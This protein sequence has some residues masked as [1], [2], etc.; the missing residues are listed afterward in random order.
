MDNIFLYMYMFL[1]I[2]G[3]WSTIPKA[4]IHHACDVRQNGIQNPGPN[5]NHF[6]FCKRAHFEERLGRRISSD[7]IFGSD[8]NFSHAYV[9]CSM[10]SSL[11][12]DLI[13][14]DRIGI[15]FEATRRS[16]FPKIKGYPKE[17]LNWWNNP[18]GDECDSSGEIPF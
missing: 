17:L 11:G 3:T 10:E 12:T 16:S 7:E 6:T 5:L 9:V 14:I 1:G 4:Y 13:L 15:N 18:I 8:F 2:L